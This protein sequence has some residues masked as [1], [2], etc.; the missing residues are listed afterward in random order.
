[1]MVFHRGAI[2]VGYFSTTAKMHRN[3][4]MC[5]SKFEKFHMLDTLFPQSQETSVP[6]RSTPNE[7]AKAPSVTADDLYGMYVVACSAAASIT[8]HHEYVVK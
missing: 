1:M 8:I 7:R 4:K 6:T 5:V 2:G 3:G